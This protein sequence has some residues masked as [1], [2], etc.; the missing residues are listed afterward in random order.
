MYGPKPYIAR[1]KCPSGQRMTSGVVMPGFKG[2]K[3]RPRHAWY[4]CR[5]KVWNAVV[6]RCRLLAV[7]KVSYQDVFVTQSLPTGINILLGIGR[8]ATGSTAFPRERRAKLE[9][10]PGDWYTGWYSC[11]PVPTVVVVL[12]LPL[13]TGTNIAL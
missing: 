2:K 12:S 6:F 5:P 13:H 1:R 8:N 3:I 10:L 4:N 11:C 9:R 7:G